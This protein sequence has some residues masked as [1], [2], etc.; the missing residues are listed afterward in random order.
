[1]C[2]LYYYDSYNSY[3]TVVSN[4]N[5]IFSFYMTVIMTFLYVKKVKFTGQ[6]VMHMT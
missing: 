1:M 2:P 6:N 3:N 5:L 4:S